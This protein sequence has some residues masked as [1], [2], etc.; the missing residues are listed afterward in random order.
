MRMEAIPASNQYQFDFWSD[1]NTANPRLFV[2]RGDTAFTAF[3]RNADGI[4]EVDG[5]APLFTLTPNPT[6]G[7]VTITVTQPEPQLILT[8]RDAAGHEVMRKEFSIVNSQ[9]SIPLDLRH[10][11]AGAY[12]V[13][14]STPTASSTQRL[15]VK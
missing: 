11:P 2:V 3:F 12:F 4:E 6:K 10:L 13:T 8:L 9:F 15:V 7:K 5:T 1:G 14:L